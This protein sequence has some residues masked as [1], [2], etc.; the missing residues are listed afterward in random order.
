MRMFRPVL[1][2][3]MV[4]AAGCAGSPPVR[5]QLQPGARIGILN[6]L[7]SQMTH[8]DVGSFRVDSFTNVYNVNWNLP[9]YFNGVIEKDL[10]ARGNYMLIPIAVNASADWKQSMATSILSAVNAWMPGDLKAFIEQTAKENRLDMIISVSSYDSGAWE[11]GSCFEIA[12]NAV[13]TKGF[14]LYTRTSA[15][16]GLSNL[17]PVGQ[18]TATP[19]A[20]IIVAIFQ[21]QPAALAAYGQAPCSKSSLTDFPWGSDLQLLSPEVIQKIRP[22]VEQLSREAAQNA[23]R[24]G[25]LLP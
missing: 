18:N 17:L 7:G 9:G 6:V 5:L 19:Y 14:G 22:H 1:F 16:S 8:V 15:L 24:N 23:L 11:Q 12:K 21:P 2:L 4:S 3:M 13:A 25:G 10:K 20:N